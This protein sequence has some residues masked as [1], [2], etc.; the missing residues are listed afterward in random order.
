[1]IEEADESLH[2]FHLG[3]GGPDM[4]LRPTS[5]EQEDLEE[6]YD[7]RFG[8]PSREDEVDELEEFLDDVY[9]GAGRFAQHFHD[10]VSVTSFW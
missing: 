4:T 9:K 1:M 6:V 7:P 2:H 8:I 10:A 3:S 5:R